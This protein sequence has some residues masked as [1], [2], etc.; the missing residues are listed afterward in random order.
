MKH[1]ILA[2]VLTLAAQ[3]AEPSAR[4]PVLAELFTSEGC[5]SCPSADALLM[6]LDQAQPVAGAQIIVLSEHVDYWNSQGWNDPYSSA[7]FTERQR[8]YAH[9][10]VAE[11][12]T[13]QIVIDGRSECNGSNGKAIL[14][15]VT[16]EAARPKTPVKI[17]TA[18]RDGNDAIVSF[19]VDASSGKGNVW[20]AIADDR[21]QT[22][23]KRGENSGKTLTHVSVVRSLGKVGAVTKAAGLEKTVRVPLKAEAGDLRVVVFVAE[24]GGPVMGSAMEPLK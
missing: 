24:S 4:V 5:S 16:R 3:A 13:P 15:A 14:A 2:T 9:S 22:S 19:T 11:T 18:T 6:K 20:V 7:Q 23:V 12:Y 17:V 1:F 10:L 21:D 8:M